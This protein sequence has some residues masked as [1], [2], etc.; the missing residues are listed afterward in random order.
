MP[1]LSQPKHSNTTLPVHLCQSP[2]IYTFYQHH[3][4]R[5]V[6]DSGATCNLFPLSALH[7]FGVKV[8]PSSQSAHQADG[9]PQWKLYVY[10][11]HK[12]ISIWSPS[13]LK[14]RCRHFSWH[15]LCLSTILLFAQPNARSYWVMVE[16]LYVDQHQPLKQ[17]PSVSPLY[18]VPH[19][20]HHH[21][22]R[23][24]PGN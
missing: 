20:S 15:S 11:W 8:K 16:Y 1:N 9:S 2:Y 10:P 19:Q 21:L 3:H 5:T 24:L 22:T 6:I 17:T 7:W 23:W 12:Y 14:Y 13:C 4:A 18:S